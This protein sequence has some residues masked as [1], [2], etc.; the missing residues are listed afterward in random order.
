MRWSQVVKG[1]AFE[2]VWYASCMILFILCW[3]VTVNE[4]IK[5][6]PPHSLP[7]LLCDFSLALSRD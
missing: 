5:T 3:R 6:S 2:R 7:N 1:E 4:E